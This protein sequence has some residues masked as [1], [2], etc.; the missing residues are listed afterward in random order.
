MYGHCTPCLTSK[1]LIKS[2]MSPFSPWNILSIWQNF[3]VNLIL[4]VSS[5]YP[6]IDRIPQIKHSCSWLYHKHSAIFQVF[7]QEQ[8]KEM[9]IQ[10]DD[11]I[12][13]WWWLW[14]VEVHQEEFITTC[15]LPVACSSTSLQARGAIYNRVIACVRK[16]PQYNVGFKVEFLPK[17]SDFICAPT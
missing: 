6:Y 10:F 1:Q 12:S 15:V 7:W 11:W 16:T 17:K 9:A 3:A 13:C 8:N 14:P 2:N 5:L 4:Q